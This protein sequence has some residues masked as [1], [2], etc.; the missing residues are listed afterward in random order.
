M[1]GKV[2]VLI[3]CSNDVLVY[4][5]GEPDMQ[6]FT[7]RLKVL[8]NATAGSVEGRRYKYLRKFCKLSRKIRV[9][10]THWLEFHVILHRMGSPLHTTNLIWRACSQT[11]I[12]AVDVELRRYAILNYL[13][14]M[15]LIG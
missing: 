2:G 5:K 12:S 15:T 7:N 9:S 1:V 11:N 4:S 8:R 10:N 13:H 14:F 6:S 3:L